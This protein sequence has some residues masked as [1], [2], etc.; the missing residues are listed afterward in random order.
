MAKNGTLKKR[1]KKNCQLKRLSTMALYGTSDLLLVF[2]G[3]KRETCAFDKKELSP[4]NIGPSIAKSLQTVAFK[5]SLY[6]A[7]LCRRQDGQQYIKQK[8]VP[9]FSPYSRETIENYLNEEHE[10]LIKICN[11]L[12]IVN[13]GWVASTVPFEIT[14]EIAD[15][16]F[17]KQGGW[18]HIAEWQKQ[19]LIE[20]MPKNPRCPSCNK[21]I[22]K[23][24]YQ[25]RC[26]FGRPCSKC[27][28]K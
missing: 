8:V 14:D 5:W 11:P 20:D 6:L 16:L 17:T 10:K 22:T 3:G 18:D 21:F 24:D 9:F 27:E 12:H 23:S 19:K 4:V 28:E 25:E 2:I 13:I 1:T 26:A 15:D 7:V